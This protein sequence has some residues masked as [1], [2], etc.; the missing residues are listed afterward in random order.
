ML[1]VAF[2]A[3][4]KKTPSE[5]EQARMDREEIEEYITK[6][7]LDA[8]T[9]ASGLY[10]VI[11]NIGTGEFPNEDDDVVVRYKGYFTSGSVFDQSDDIG[12]QF[13][14]QQVIAGWTEGIPLFRQGGEGVLLI[15]SRLGYGPQGNSSIPGGSVLIFDIKLLDIVN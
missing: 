5:K 3:A 7:D 15:P 10:Y 2:I 9:T 8:D 14:L 12:A 4:C 11:N 13:N 1:V 6:N